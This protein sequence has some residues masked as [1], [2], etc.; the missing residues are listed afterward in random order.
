MPTFGSPFRFSDKITGISHLCNACYMAWMSRPPS[1][2]HSLSLEYVLRLWTE[3]MGG[4]H[5][6]RVVV[7]ILNKQMQSTDRGSPDGDRT[8]SRKARKH[9]IP[10][11]IKQVALLLTQL[12]NFHWCLKQTESLPHDTKTIK[13]CNL[14][15]ITSD[16]IYCALYFNYI[17][18]TW[19]EISR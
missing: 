6:W 19:N 1:V 13:C 12:L 16:F 10:K 4:L 18:K 17:W 9:H 5:V 8:F 3:E 11:F 7:N 14:P 15:R 2:G